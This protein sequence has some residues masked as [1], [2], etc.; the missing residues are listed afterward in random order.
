MENNLT[1]NFFELSISIFLNLH[2]TL[3]LSFIGVENG[4]SML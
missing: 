3:L 4:G 1:C 2:E